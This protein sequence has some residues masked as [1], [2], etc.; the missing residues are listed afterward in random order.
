MRIRTV[1]IGGVALGGASAL[2]ARTLHPSLPARLFA[3]FLRAQ[4]KPVTWAPDTIAADRQRIDGG[5]TPALL[6]KGVS[7]RPLRPDELG[8]AKG[9]WVGIAGARR[10]ILYL[11]GGYYLAGVTSTSRN[12]AGRLSRDLGAEVVLLEY[13]LAPEHPYPAALDAGVAAYRALLDG[14]ADPSTLAVAGDSAGGGLALAVLLRAKA[15]GLPMPAAA[16]LLSPWTDL[17]CSAESVERNDQADVIVS[18]RS[19]RA[20][21]AHYA[22][23]AALDDPGVSPLFGDLAGLP[24]LYVTVDRSE[25]LL[26][27]SLRLV[28]RAQGAGVR[29]ELEQTSGLFHIWPVLVPLLSEA[30]ETV[31]NLVRFLDHELA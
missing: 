15:E 10:H 1:V 8:D 25:A 7:A 27:D 22:G 6:G 9:E 14:G 31:T 12:L 21:A 18:A 29:C 17:T 26:D 23:A 20:A 19:A 2:V 30:R 5:P 3:A 11:H 16:V 13:P 28:E 24:P 4:V